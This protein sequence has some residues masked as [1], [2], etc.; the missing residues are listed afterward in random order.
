MGLGLPVQRRERGLEGRVSTVTLTRR[1]YLGEWSWVSSG[2]RIRGMTPLSSELVTIASSLRVGGGQDS[3]S[4]E[5]PGLEVQS[6]ARGPT[7]GEAG[8]GVQTWASVPTRGHVQGSLLTG[9]SRAGE[10]QAQ[11]WG[12]GGEKTAWGG[13][14]PGGAGAVQHVGRP[15]AMAQP[16]K[17]TPAPAEVVD[18]GP[19]AGFTHTPCWV[20]RSSGSPVL[21]SAGRRRRARRAGRSGERGPRTS[22][23]PCG[24]RHSWACFPHIF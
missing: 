11:G 8:L 19:S 13:S 3:A 24:N 1:V 12:P 23:R 4:Q 20:N 16:G 15:T 10:S 5:E 18:F 9:A 22:G 2:R 14:A 17:S 7:A 21:S 6:S